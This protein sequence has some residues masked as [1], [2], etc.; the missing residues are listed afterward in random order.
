MCKDQGY[1]HQIPSW[2]NDT[3]NVSQQGG[4][5]SKTATATSE[6]SVLDLPPFVKHVAGF[7][8]GIPKK[9]LAQAAFRCF[10]TA[11]I[12]GCTCNNY[13]TT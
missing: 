3:S 6:A 1:G 4:A 13:L 9:V 8:D 5:S 7:L 2:F 10:K 11:S 12:N